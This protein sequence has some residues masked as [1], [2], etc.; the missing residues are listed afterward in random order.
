M[1][2]AMKAMPDLVAMKS[3]VV[4]TTDADIIVQN[5]T[6]SDSDSSSECDT[7]TGDNAGDDD[8]CPSILI[9]ALEHAI[10]ACKALEG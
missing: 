5:G 6:S 3:A 7:D 8:E 2:P 4:T 1:A 10:A 9:R